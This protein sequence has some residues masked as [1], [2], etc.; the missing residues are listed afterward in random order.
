LT[1]FTSIPFF[2]AFAVTESGIIDTVGAEPIEMLDKSKNT[3]LAFPVLTGKES[4]VAQT[5]GH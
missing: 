5:P 2:N 4:F 3:V 1:N